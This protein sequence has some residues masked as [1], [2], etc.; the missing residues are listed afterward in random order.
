MN[1]KIINNL[2][3]KSK[4]ILIMAIASLAI[5]AV[6]FTGVYG[7]QKVNNAL[8]DMYH[9]HYVSSVNVLELK[10]D[11]NG[12]RAA[13]VSMMAQTEKD[14]KEKQHETVRALSRKID[15]GIE[16]AL[17]SEYA[18]NNV[19]EK[20]TQIKETWAAF[21]ATRDRELIPFVYA[22][23]LQEAKALALGVQAERFNK[24]IGLAD[25]LVKAELLEA[26]GLLDNGA[27]IYTNS[28]GV[29]I[30][31]AVISIVITVMVSVIVAT[32]ISSALRDGMSLLAFVAKGDIRRRAEVRSSD[33]IGSII[34]SANDMAST[35]STTIKNVRDAVV[36]VAT[37]TAQVAKGN[38]DLSQR[39]TEQSASVEETSSTM[40]E[41]AASIRQNAD[42]AKEANKLAAEARRTADEGGVVVDSLVRN[43][44]EIVTS[45]KKVLDITGMIDEIAFQT[46]ILALNAAVE[47]ARAGEQGRG[48]AVVAAEVRNL[49]QRSGAAAKEIATL[50]KENTERTEGGYK[51]AGDTKN[52]LNGI[53]NNVKK[54]ADLIA[55]ISASSQEQASGVEQINKAVTQM[56][57]VTQQNAA[58]VEEISTSTQGM[59]NQAKELLKHVEYF[60]VDEGGEARPVEMVAHEHRAA[61]PVAFKGNG[62][63]HPKEM[64]KAIGASLH[65]EGADGKDGFVEV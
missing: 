46:N 54:T 26:K 14:G 5:V 28:F 2:K 48:F 35:L 11:L 44:E 37:A 53:V 36:Q 62:S 59:A 12:V 49:A 19:K 32:A 15:D 13:L 34:G 20:L 17:K 3:V 42:S 38:E 29:I 40:E 60:K 1:I 43:M 64:A 50:L 25:D 45:G 6:G 57:Q 4:L 21:S 10:S 9:K 55:E 16:G 47:A 61:Q 58:L 52:V 30:A 23:K 63:K 27:R 65:H 8:S 31:I 39:V 33:E 56:D 24:L 22:G 51:L 7:L 41:M 18:R